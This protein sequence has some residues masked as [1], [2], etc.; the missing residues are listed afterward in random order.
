VLQS[1]NRFLLDQK[2]I[3]W[4]DEVW[5]SWHADDGYMLENYRAT[6]EEM[7]L[8]PPENIGDMDEPSESDATPEAEA[9][10]VSSE[11]TN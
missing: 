11:K 7:L 10:H 5:L 4:G 8:L 6:D 1:H 9:D 2:P 3:T